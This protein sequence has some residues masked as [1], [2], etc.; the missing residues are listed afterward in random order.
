[1][2]EVHIGSN[3]TVYGRLLKIV[4]Y[5]DVATR[6]RFEVSRQRTFGMLKP[7]VYTNIGK[8]LDMI[9]SS[10]FKVSKLKMSRFN[11]NS[12]GEFYSEHRQKAFY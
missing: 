10:G 8:I 6:R 3:I 11:A 1:M 9:Y 5:G 2:E 7:D 12:A 4:D